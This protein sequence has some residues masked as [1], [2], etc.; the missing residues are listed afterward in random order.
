MKKVKIHLVN[1]DIMIEGYNFP[2][3]FTLRL[4]FI[5]DDITTTEELGN[6]IDTIIDENSSR[7]FILDPNTCK[8]CGN[9][10]KEGDDNG[11]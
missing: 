4:K 7:E 10:L 2:G 11:T 5:L 9:K 1:R 6:I 3:E 8:Y